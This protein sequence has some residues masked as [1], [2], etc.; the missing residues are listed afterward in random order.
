MEL[1][2]I[3][4]YTEDDK[5]AI[6]RDYLLPRQRERAALSDDE[7]TMVTA[8]VSMAT[9]RQVRADVGMTGEVTLNGRVLPI[10]GVKQKLLAAQRAGLSTVFIPQRNEPDLDDVP[11][12]VL[13]ALDVKPM[14]DVAEIVAQALEPA[15]ETATVAA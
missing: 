12:E 3:D 10:G 6:A 1:V 14:T 5:V 11:A 9:G 13:E 7:V 4:G 8:L 2:Q 15:A